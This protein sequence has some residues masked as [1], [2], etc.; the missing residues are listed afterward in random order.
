MEKKKTWKSRMERDVILHDDISKS[1]VHGGKIISEKLALLSFIM[2]ITLILIGLWAL[3]NMLLGL[4]FPVNS[5]NVILMI[6]VIAIGSLST[7]GGYFIYR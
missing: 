6:L 2:G 4:G 3:F 7:L 1:G 5:A